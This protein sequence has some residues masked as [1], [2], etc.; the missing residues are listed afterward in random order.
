MRKKSRHLARPHI[1]GMTL[2]VEQNETP[3]LV[4]VGMLGTGTVMM[5]T[6]HQPNLIQEFRRL[7]SVY[8]Y[9]ENFSWL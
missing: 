9:P 4:Q 3:R 2:A 5:R 1:L 7:L 6:Q 8:L